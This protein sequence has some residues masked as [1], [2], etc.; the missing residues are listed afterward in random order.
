M[1]KSSFG[2]VG[3]VDMIFCISYASLSFVHPYFAKALSVLGHRSSVYL[4]HRAAW[5]SV[6]GPPAIPKG[7]QTRF[8]CFSTFLGPG[9][10]SKAFSRP[11]DR[12]SRQK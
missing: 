1:K 10:Y 4:P 8:F 11:C 2:S 5:A 9:T 7:A 3:T 12:I 6:S